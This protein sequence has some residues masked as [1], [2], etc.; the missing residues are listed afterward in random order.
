[1]IRVS[2]TF[3]LL[4][5]R[6]AVLHTDATSRELSAVEA[7]S[8]QR[9]CYEIHLNSPGRRPLKAGP[10]ACLGGSDSPGLSARRDADGWP[11]P[12]LDVCGR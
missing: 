7:K 6:V 12:A 8:V 4:A 1:M 3:D 9:T 11:I 10:S 5:D 2:D